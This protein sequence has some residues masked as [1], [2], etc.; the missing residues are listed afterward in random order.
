MW[1][2]VGQPKAIALLE[3]SLDKEC[4]SHAYLFVGP[5]HV[6]KMTLAQNLAQAVNCEAEERPCIQC[7]SCR[8]IAAGKHADVQVV[9]LTSEGKTE[10]S[11]EQVREIRASISLPPYEGKYK[12]FII[13]GAEHLSAE[14][15]NCLLKT[16][17]EPPP[18]A[19]LILLTA[20][21]K[22]L[23]PTI[24]SRCQRVELHPLPL[25]VIK[26]MLTQRYGVIDPKAELLAR[27]SNGC[28]GWAL[29]A[30]Q[31]EKLLEQR[32]Q[33]L[34]QLTSL[35]HAS[36][37]ERLS[38]AAEWAANFSKNRGQLE[39]VLALWLNWWRD[40]L[41]V[42]GGDSEHI[43]NIDHE[44][45][46]L[47]QARSYN[48]RQIKDFILCLQAAAEQLELN[49]NPRLVLEVLMLSIP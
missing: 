28:L 34:A 21:E 27:L 48:L 9:G 49:A 36:R 2:V 47:N 38:Y 41:L 33:T 37:Q 30:V 19:L 6:G 11:I 46:L 14:A 4:L 13:D 31:D 42:K 22:I 44:S 39:E 26:E 17:E 16:L 18:R 25:P 3:R 5:P 23:L 12:V 20:R 29:S 8:R 40:L 1:Q 7:A 45:M 35:N 15:S 10:I 43:T 24:A 32:C